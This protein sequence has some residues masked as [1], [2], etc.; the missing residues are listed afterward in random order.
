VGHV[1]GSRRALSVF[2]IICSAATGLCF[3]AVQ[4]PMFL[5]LRCSMGLAQAGLFPCT[6][7][8]MKNWFPYWQWGLSNGMLTAFQQMG[9]AFVPIAAGYVASEFGWRWTFPIFAVPG[10]LWA[11]WFFYW[12]RDRPEE[13]SSVSAGELAEIREPLGNSAVP[14]APHHDEPVPWRVLLLSPALAMI[15][16]QQFF[17]GAAY[18]FYSTWFATYLREGRHVDIKTAGWLTSLPLWANAV[19][20]LVGGG[21]SDWLL[22]RTGSRRISRQCL[23]VLTQ[24]SS[25]AFVV[26]AYQVSDPT[27]AVLIISVGSF[28]AAGAG[29]IAYA[30]TIDMGGNHVRPV[31]S[32]MNMWGNLGSLLFPQVLAWVVGEGA[33]TNWD[34][35]LPLFAAMYGIAGLCWLGFNPNRSIVPESTPAISD[36]R[37][38]GD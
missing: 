17:R 32:L 9:G 6:T 8:T 2:A 1:W 37:S 30:I 15:C 36:R 38:S 13:H 27:M 29:P 14:A 11:A 24:L 31:F 19:G 5:F 23:A 12:F 3:F 28:C 18:I 25:A 4:F 26:V 22:V 35:A 33:N 21:F 7:G 20:C 16:T 10:F 34:S